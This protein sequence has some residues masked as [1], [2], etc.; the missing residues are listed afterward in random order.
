[1]N[2]AL[3]A[4]HVW[5]LQVVAYKADGTVNSTYPLVMGDPA[6]P[7][8]PLPSAIEISFLAMSP[9]AARTVASVSNSPADWMNHAAP[10]YMRL[11]ASNAYE[12]RTHV[13]F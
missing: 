10:N 1:V 5:N 4:T 3:V 7:S 8:A 2:D 11:I 6:N 12:F 9:N 13:N